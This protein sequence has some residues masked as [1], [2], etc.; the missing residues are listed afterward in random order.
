MT[1]SVE[2]IRRLA[3][4]LMILLAERLKSIAEVRLIDCDSEIG[5]GALPNFHLPSVGIALRPGA[6][7]GLQDEALQNLARAF[8][9][10]PVPVIGRVSQGEF[11]LDCRALDDPEEL[12]QQLASLEVAP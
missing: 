7:R 6:P 10:L 1:R 2:E 9:E 5:S 3:E 4:P 8:R 11:I 12:R